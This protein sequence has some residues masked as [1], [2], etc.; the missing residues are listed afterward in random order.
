MA[1]RSV[2]ARTNSF[3]GNVRLSSHW[4]GIQPCLSPQPSLFLCFLSFLFLLFLLPI[5]NSVCS[6]AHIAS[7]KPSAGFDSLSTNSCIY[8]DKKQTVIHVHG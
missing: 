7:I 3:R 5:V 1:L 6:R 4:I 2:H 8:K